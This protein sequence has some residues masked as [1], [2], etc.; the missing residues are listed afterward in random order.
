MC[1]ICGIFRGQGLTEKDAKAVASS[2]ERMHSRGPDGHGTF[3]NGKVMLGHKRLAILD[4]RQ[5]QQPWEDPDTGVVLSYNGEIYN[6]PELKQQLEQKGHV[7]RTSC[8]T[9][10]LMRGYLE[11]GT[12]VVDHLN[13][14]FAFAILDQR[15][16]RLVLARDRLG[17]KPLFIFEDNGLVVFSSSIAGMLVHPDIQPKLDP[18]AMGHYFLTIRTT[19]G[20]RTLIKGVQSLQPGEMISLNTSTGESQRSRYWQLPVVAAADKTKADCDQEMVDELR[21]RFDKAVKGQLITDV[22]LG[23]FLSGGLDSS[24]LAGSVLADRSSEFHAYSIGYERDGYNEWEYVRDTAGFHGINCRY[25]KLDEATYLDDWRSLVKFKGSPLSTPNEVPIA[26]LSK[27]FRDEFTVAMTGEGADEVFGGYTVPAFSAFDYDRSRGELGGIDAEALQRG[28]GKTVLGTRREHF[29]TVNSWINSSIQQN[30]FP[31]LFGSGES[32]LNEVTGW[33]DAH[34]ERL[35]A[36]TT[37]DAYMHVLAQVNLEGLL[38]RLDS[39]TMYASVEGRVPFTDHEIAEWVFSL[40]DNLKMQLAP[41]TDPAQV[42]AMNIYDLNANGLVDTKRLLRAAFDDRVAES[43]LTRPKVSF[44]VPFR[45]WFNSSLKE[46]YRSVLQQSPLVND[47]LESSV[48]HWE[49]T[50]KSEV[51]GMLAWPLMNLALLEEC[52]GIHL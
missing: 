40:A 9:E 4:P 28:Y 39:S 25:V 36:C 26:R 11:W 15:H 32:P 48:M 18:V 43:V 6:Y 50:T 21:V 37:F 19:M 42:Q 46:Q 31:S 49:M 12:E 52:W 7:F 44:P 8:D 13:G 24:V 20:R 34:F 17:V 5:G 41:G 14:M 23:G 33:Y 10:A 1:G 3:R 51:N 30:I 38:S 2:L 29:L 47:I 35:Q 27:A 45:E 16:D 22:P